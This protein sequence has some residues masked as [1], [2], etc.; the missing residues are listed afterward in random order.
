MQSLWR[1]IKNT[2]LLSTGILGGCL[3]VAFGTAGVADTA[4]VTYNGCENVSTGVIRLLPNQLAAP[5]NACILAGNP[6]LLKLPSLLEVGV[7]W[8]QV[9]PQGPQGMKGDT[10]SAG[11]QG[12]QGIPGTGATIAAL[13][14]GDSNCPAGGVKVAD[15]SGHVAYVCNGAAGQQ[16]SQGPRGS[17]GTGALV[18][19]EPSGVNCAAGGVKV[20][21]GSANVAYACNGAKGDPGPALASISSLTG[22]ACTT[23]G[24]QAGTVSVNT[25]ADNSITL[26]C[27]GAAP[28]CIHSNGAGQTYQDCTN[29]PGT[30]GDASSYNF[31]MANEAKQALENTITG[32]AFLCG[33]VGVKCDNTVQG[34]DT[35]DVS[36]L[37]VDVVWQ[38]AGALAGHVDKTSAASPVCPTAGDPT[39][40]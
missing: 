27:V 26:S 12:P 6:I 29:P 22:I 28:S 30:P 17:P 39:W 3:L 4:S 23:S 19:A 40:T 18:A 20:T 9:G 32:C 10:G 14:P 25:G 36:F 1:R 37:G 13:N 31:D 11:S 7:S 5:F 38:Y 2:R 34:A 21:D 24:N 8:N 33:F 35:V 15:G 16:G